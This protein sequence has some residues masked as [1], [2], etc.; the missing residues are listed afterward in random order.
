MSSTTLS[1]PEKNLETN[2]LRCIYPTKAQELCARENEEGKFSARVIFL[3]TQSIEHLLISAVPHENL[4]PV[5]ERP[6]SGPDRTLLY[7]AVQRLHSFKKFF[8]MGWPD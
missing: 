3:L 7:K 1:L 6:A 5:A 2:T 4:P 8:V